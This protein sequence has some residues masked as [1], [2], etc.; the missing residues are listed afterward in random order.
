[1]RISAYPSER[2]RNDSI[3]RFRLI[4]SLRG[5]AAVAVV[6]AHSFGGAYIDLLPAT[7]PRPVRF[8]FHQGHTGVAIFFVISGFV[9]AHSLRDATPKPEY[10]G[11]FIL[12][13]QLRLSP[14]YWTTMFLVLLYLW[15]IALRTHSW[16]NIP[17]P[18]P[19]LAHMFYLQE[20]THQYT[21]IPVAWTLCLEM[22]FYLAF[23]CLLFCREMLPPKLRAPWA[24][25]VSAAAALF[26]LT[27]YSDPFLWPHFPWL[28]PYWPLFVLGIWTYWVVRGELSQR[29]LILLWIVCGISAFF[30]TEA[31]LFWACATSGLIYGAF[32]CGALDRWLSSWPF[33]FLGK[34]SYSLYLVHVTVL[35]IIIDFAYKHGPHTVSFAWTAVVAAILASI[36]CAYLFFMCVERPSVKLSARFKA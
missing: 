20:V 16:T 1:M 18:T 28:L 30:K 34:I 3:G 24:V 7:T 21:F 10:F 31:P 11:R 14:P 29:Y 12:R 23:M 26:G 4:D 33:Q 2:A 19:F 8:F 5:I 27:Y 32:R 15:I 22:M 9:I 6:M 36:G 17:H 25:A 35:A 13:R